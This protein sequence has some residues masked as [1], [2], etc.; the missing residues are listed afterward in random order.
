MSEI[1]P[2]HLVFHAVTFFE[3]D[4]LLTIRYLSAGPVVK[5]MMAV[6]LLRYVGQCLHTFCTRLAYLKCS[7]LTSI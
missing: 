1:R 7:H 6:A 2:E 3:G 4:K 5:D